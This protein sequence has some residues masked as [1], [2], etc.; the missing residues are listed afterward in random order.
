MKTVLMTLLLVST[1]LSQG[2]DKYDTTVT[3]MG[4]RPDSFFI[5]PI[6]RYLYFNAVITT[7]CPAYTS[8]DFVDFVSPNHNTKVERIPTRTNP[9]IRITSHCYGSE[10]TGIK[11]ETVFSTEDRYYKIESG[12]NDVYFRIIG[13]SND[14]KARIEFSYSPYSTRI[15]DIPGN[16][17]PRMRNEKFKLKNSRGTFL[18]NGKHVRKTNDFKMGR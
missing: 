7:S 4:A 9:L 2:I 11:A 14:Y 8:A 3:L 18:A 10:V 15:A 12:G 16:K 17:N 6:N 1:A 13:I 5:H